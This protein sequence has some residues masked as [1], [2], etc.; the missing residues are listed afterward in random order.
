[1]PMVK[2]VGTSIFFK[3]CIEIFKILEY[4]RKLGIYVFENHRKDE[5][6]MKKNGISL[7]TLNI[8]M[9]VL[10]LF[11]GI[12]LIVAVNRSRSVFNDNQEFTDQYLEWRQGSYDLQMASDYL[13]EQMRNFTVTGDKTYLDN[14]FTEAN[15]TCRREHALQV[16]GQGHARSSSYINLSAAMEESVSLMKREYYAARLTVMAYGY[17]ITTYPKEIQDVKLMEPDL[18]LDVEAMKELARQMM[19]GEEYRKR[20]EVISTHMQNCLAEL[21]VEMEK[22]QADYSSSLANQLFFE[23]ALAI[24]IIVLLLAIVLYTYNLVI[25]PLRNSVSLIRDDEDLPISGAYEIRF[26]AKTY[27]M[28]HHNNMRSKEKL[29]YEATHDKLTGMYNR[30]GYDFLMENIDLETSALILL[31]IDK[32]KGINDT[33]G[34]D[35]G[36]RILKRV[37]DTIFA[38]FRVND[39]ICR[40]GGDEIAI[41]MVQCDAS[42]SP[43]LDAKIKKI[44]KTLS[45]KQDKDPVVS[46][47]VGIA[48]GEKGISAETLFKRADTC[49]YEVKDGEKDEVSFFK[50]E[51]KKRPEPKI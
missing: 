49:L 12:G 50:N 8:I 36:D 51:K 25:L 6:V 18:S 2:N 26:L 1:M 38:N 16:L 24:C 30:R 31:D 48:F 45:I 47:S 33:Y 7:K 39:Y 34:H 29:T 41:L 44:N 11:F 46:V 19:H 35:T 5:C 13:T 27:N 3:R 28:I 43:L 15:V 40:I 23:H 42:V 9:L 21:D 17:D 20:K 32:F 10:A 14:Y 37:A 4:N 22:K